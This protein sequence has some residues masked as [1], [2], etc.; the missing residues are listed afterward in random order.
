MDILLAVHYNLMV[1]NTNIP[2]PVTV[3]RLT[4]ISLN[5]IFC[6]KSDVNYKNV[7]VK[8]NFKWLMQQCL[9]CQYSMIIISNC[10]YGNLF[11][12]DM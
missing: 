10:S 6:L 3:R 1:L 9:T 8:G 4:T 5:Y 7:H 11:F 2:T 12:T